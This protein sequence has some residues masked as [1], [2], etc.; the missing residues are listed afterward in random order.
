VAG[1]PEEDVIAGLVLPPVEAARARQWLGGVREA[2]V[3]W[4]LLYL[5]G[6]KGYGMTIAQMW[7]VV[8]LLLNGPVPERAPLAVLVLLERIDDAQRAGLFAAGVPAAP[9]FKGHPPL[10]DSLAGNAPLATVFARPLREELL[11]QAIPGGHELRTRLDAFFGGWPGTDGPGQPFHLG[12]LS[13]KLAE[14]SV[15]SGRGG[16]W[17]ETAEYVRILR[18]KYTF[19]KN[20][21]SRINDYLVQMSPAEQARAR[22]FLGTLRTEVHDYHLARGFPEPSKL[23]PLPALDE[24]LSRLYAEAARRI[25]ASPELGDLTVTPPASQ[26][27]LLRKAL[28]PAVV[29]AAPAGARPERFTDQFQGQGF[30][31]RLRQ[32]FL[33]EI[34]NDESRLVHGKGTAERAIP[35]NLYAREH[36][37]EIANL[38]LKWIRDVF[39]FARLPQRLVVA[40]PGDEGDIYDEFEYFARLWRSWTPAALRVHASEYFL[41]IFSTRPE[42]APAKVA[43]EHGAAVVFDIDSPLNEEARIAGE[44]IDELLRDTGIV[45]RITEIL[46]NWGGH[47][48]ATTNKILISF[49]RE[50][51][52]DVEKLWKDIAYTLIHE[53]MHYLEDPLY[54]KRARSFPG[55][56]NSREYHTLTEGGATLLAELVWAHVMARLKET[57]E[58]GRTNL[59]SWSEIILGPYH[60]GTDLSTGPQKLRALVRPRYT[61]ESEVIRLVGLVGIENLL[62]AF[63]DGQTQKITG[64]PPGTRGSML[65]PHPASERPGQPTPPDEPA[66]DKGGPPEQPSRPPAPPT[67][68]DKPAD[69]KGGPPEQPS[70]PPAPAPSSRLTHEPVDKGEAPQSPPRRD[71]G[72]AARHQIS[73]LRREDLAQAVSLDHRLFAGEAMSEADIEEQMRAGD[74]LL[75]AYDDA[76]ALIGFAGLSIGGQ[77]SGRHGEVTTIGVDPA[78]QGRGVGTRLLR[79]L[80]AAAERRR[81]PVSLHVRT[82]NE[83]A[84]AWYERHGF[85]RIRLVR[86]YYSRSGSDA[87]LM[88]RP[89]P[90]PDHPSPARPETGVP[91]QAEAVS[92]PVPRR[93]PEAELP[94]GPSLPPA[95]A[96]SPAEE[97]ERIG[98]SPVRGTDTSTTDPSRTLDEA[99]RETG[100][101]VSE[102][103]LVSGPGQPVQQLEFGAMVTAPATGSCLLY[104]AIAAAP[105]VVRERLIASGLLTEGHP[106]AAWLARPGQVRSDSE[107]RARSGL[108][109]EHLLWQ[110]GDL[111]RRFTY[112]YLQDNRAVLPEAVRQVRRHFRE[113]IGRAIHG[114]P[115][116]ELIDALGR[117]G[118]TYVTEPGY[119]PTQI[120]RQTYLDVRT[121]ELAGPGVDTAAARV[122]AEAEVPLKPGRSTDLADE[123]LNEQELLDYLARHDVHFQLDG[124]NDDALRDYLLASMTLGSGP[125][126]DIEF[127]AVRGAVL[128][129]EQHWASNEGE[130]FLP[131]LAHALGIQTR[132]V[133]NRRPLPRGEFEDIEPFRLQTVGD[134]GNPLFDLYYNGRNHYNGS[135]P[136][137]FRY[138]APTWDRAWQLLRQHF[139]PAR[140]E[141][142]TQP[143]HLYRN[144]SEVAAALQEGSEEEAASLAQ[145]LGA[146]LPARQPSPSSSTAPMLSA[147]TETTPPPAPAQEATTAS[148]PA[149]AVESPA[150]SSSAVAETS[151]S[152]AQHS[153]QTRAPRPQFLRRGSRG[154]PQ[155]GQRSPFVLAEARRQVEGGTV[156]VSPTWYGHVAAGLASLRRT[157]SFEAFAAVLPGFVPDGMTIDYEFSTARPALAY[158]SAESVRGDSYFAILAPVAHDLTGLAPDTSG[159]IMFPPGG[160]RVARIDTVRGRRVV[161]LVHQGEDAP[162]PSGGAQGEPPAVEPS[163]EDAPGDPAH[164]SGAVPPSSD[165]HEEPPARDPPSSG[166]AGRAP[167][168]GPP[169]GGASEGGI[170]TAASRR[171]IP[172]RI[173]WVPGSWESR[174]GRAMV[175]E[176]IAYPGLFVMGVH[177]RRDGRWLVY[178]GHSRGFP[179]QGLGRAHLEALG[180]HPGQAIMVV[181]QRREGDGLDKRLEALGEAVGA[182]IWYPAPGAVLEFGADYLLRAVRADDGEPADLWLRHESQSLRESSGIEVPA[183]FAAGS[184]GALVPTEG[185]SGFGFRQGWASVGPTEFLDRLDLLG[186]EPEPGLFDVLLQRNGRGELGL[187]GPAGRF[188]PV[189]RDNL[190][191]VPEGMHEVRLV[192]D[193]GEGVRGGAAALAWWPRPA[194]G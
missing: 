139:P 40:E 16:Q 180:W 17:P 142:P 80:L 92:A 133:Q 56:I 52:K 107:T 158:A 61:A 12:L 7:A 27:E 112:R 3:D 128:D 8:R 28:I 83:S 188:I 109:Q 131:L 156:E 23:H 115:R 102:Q 123:A 24:I 31:D 50:A 132:V 182:D 130:A 74:L 48:H 104:A 88:S 118:V 189:S 181:T 159:M 49:F 15:E 161:S 76:G 192:M 32:A 114:W 190:P 87:Y 9:L 176:G 193:D 183:W 154:D 151:A 141:G 157:E 122:L 101:Q 30:R 79:S 108:L 37:Q 58:D 146:S 55:E 6:T 82:D 134:A 147:V 150:V 117:R 51:G 81:L 10:A 178:D 160:F 29:Q 172:R 140:G 155:P 110:A 94:G 45:G 149:L 124:L 138:D 67:V 73:R 33:E 103:P 143:A 113:P 175:M 111:L 2:M 25:P 165:A 95:V 62:A 5:A 71:D 174:H 34:G 168:P 126:D 19:D 125:L 119:V 120:L 69:D 127:R 38:V 100:G 86:G 162:P 43:A 184:D 145:A 60:A 59:E 1:L 137:Q 185:I 167:S 191:V 77:R 70:R 136:G 153:P 135:A 169:G 42:S 170:V 20:Y 54:S 47:T 96:V 163:A 179:G 89:A 66:D 36:I 84:I 105:E 116:G 106:V 11:E 152:G 65:A 97:V 53:I 98:T 99:A 41:S 186:R 171:I 44:V 78:W 26:A 63:L 64:A 177:V 187:T 164:P 22:S 75:G 194:P 121:S 18:F 173:I 85:T 144:L 91:P 46:R 72:A 166:I 13:E 39:P 57:G 148:S 129:W 68:P 21:T 93:S 35:E 4:V 90:V 14:Y